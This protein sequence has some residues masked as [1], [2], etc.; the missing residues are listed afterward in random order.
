MLML[1]AGGRMGTHPVHAGGTSW[2]SLLAD[3]HAKAPG[4]CGLR[5]MPGALSQ[6]LFLRGCGSGLGFLGWAGAV[7]TWRGL[8]AVA[9]RTPEALQGHW[10]QHTHSDLIQELG[11]GQPGLPPAAQ[12]GKGSPSNLAA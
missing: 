7:L 10:V 9:L 11:E 1:G 8:L 12:A 6:V 4:A 5:G 3:A 2:I